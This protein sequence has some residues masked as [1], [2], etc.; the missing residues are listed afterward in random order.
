MAEVINYTPPKTVSAFI[1][2]HRKGE[3]FYSWITGPIGSG[4]TT[5]NFF[6]LCYMA[7]LQEPGPDGIRRSRAVVVRNTLPQLRDTTIASWL[8]W[9][10]DGQAG[11]WHATNYKFVLRFDDVECEVLFRPLDTPEDIARVLS[12]EITF[13]IL[14]EFVRIPREIIDSLSA[15]CG[16]YPATKDGGATNWGMWGASNT[17]TEDNWWFDYLHDRAAVFKG[18]A[19]RDENDRERA[20][21]ALAGERI[22]N[23]TVFVQPSGF[24]VAAENLEN[25]PGGRD[26]YIQQADGKKK[27]WIKQFI[28][29]EWGYSAA[30][31][32]VVS[33][34]N[35]GLHVAKKEL[36]FNPLLELVVGL[37]PGLGGMGW[38]FTQQDLDGR[39]LC[40]G[41]LVL[42]NVGIERA[43][44][45]H[46]KPYLRRR[47]PEANVVIAPDP[48]AA[49][50]AQTDERAV[51]DVVKRHFHV[52]IETNNRLPLRL[53]AID[54]FAARLTAEGPALLLDPVHCP[55]T[56]RAL[57][58]GWRYAVNL[59]KGVVQGAAPEKNQHSHIGDGFG[60]A[61]RYHHKLDTRYGADRSRLVSAHGARRQFR[62]QVAPGYHFR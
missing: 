51:V 46:V 18:H 35:S 41:E 4:K 23:A 11:D 6:K 43:I 1:A 21:R 26:Y 19:A 14:D 33:S 60:Y 58:G 24:D 27:A 12:L 59:R 20:A 7:K 30:G 38:S 42:E 2:D 40:L 39:L 61:A 57:A 32:P 29:V 56:I 28:E 25:L 49:N 50:R 9:F 13:A 31:M 45:D 37:D 8:M 36:L 48:A 16:R 15:R 55:R 53:D 47:F 52:Q 10:K 54:Y 5:G 22:P 62:P 3:L 34:F 44:T 17:D